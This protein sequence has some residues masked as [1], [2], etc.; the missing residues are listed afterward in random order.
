MQHNKV[1]DGRILALNIDYTYF[2][3][4]YKLHDWTFVDPRSHLDICTSNWFSVA[5]YLQPAPSP[6]DHSVDERE[7]TVEQWKELIYQEVMEY[8]SIH[9]N[10]T[11]SSSSQPSPAS[12]SAEPNGTEPLR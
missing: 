6:Y 1:T 3:L 7:H 5:L 2:Y 10:T 12:N 4:L 9:G 8:E 11:A